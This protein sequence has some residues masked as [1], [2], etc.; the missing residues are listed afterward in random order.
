MAS[1]TED[2]A[3]RNVS[4]R[5]AGAVSAAA[6]AGSPLAAS[7]AIAQ[8]NSVPDHA[9]VRSSVA[10]GQLEALE[11]L[12]ATEADTLEAIVACLIPSD[13]NGPGATEARAA[14]Y[15]DRA[16]IG[17]LRTSATPTRL[18]SPPLTPMRYRR[19]SEALASQPG[20]GAD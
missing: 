11:T 4:R 13:E 15:I 10:T 12:T 1:E 14:H 17:P 19:R 8:E 16:L 6:I 7:A 2:N 9:A 20:R 5:Q 3:P 18:A